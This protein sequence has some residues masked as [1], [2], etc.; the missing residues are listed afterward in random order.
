[1][2]AV[3]GLI[4]ISVYSFLR[5]VTYD[6]GNATNAYKDIVQKMTD[7]MKLIATANPSQSVKE[8]FVNCVRKVLSK[9]GD[10]DEIYTEYMSDMWKYVQHEDGK[11]LQEIWGDNTMDNIKNVRSYMRKFRSHTETVQQTQKLSL[12]MLILLVLVIAPLLYTL[13][14]V[15]YTHDPKMTVLGVGGG[16]LVFTVVVTWYG[17]FASALSL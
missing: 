9:E 2:L 7:T 16:V 10:V 13:Y 8:Y 6:M 1:M 14:H 4:A 11:E 3:V 12:A 17:W 5:R 15:A